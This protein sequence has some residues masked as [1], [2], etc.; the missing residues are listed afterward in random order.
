MSYSI[1]CLPKDLIRY[2]LLRSLDPADYPYVLLSSKLFHVLS[3]TERNEMYKNKYVAQWAERQYQNLCNKIR[4]RLRKKRTL[5][6]YDQYRNKL[7]QCPRC[8]NWRTN[9][10]RAHTPEQ[11][12]KMIQTLNEQFKAILEAKKRR[13][14]ELRRRQKIQQE[15]AWRQ[16]YAGLQPR[17]TAYD[18]Y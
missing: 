9:Y 2:I 15:I 14:W 4:V 3:K 12:A 17:V 7:Y 11:C 8:R 13:E 16:Y 10:K 5:Q 18:F 1:E 6:K